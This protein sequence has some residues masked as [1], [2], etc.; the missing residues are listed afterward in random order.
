MGAVEIFF[1][2]QAL[3]SSGQEPRR[4]KTNL[5][6]DILAGDKAGTEG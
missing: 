3:Q 1:R 5:A 2:E 4:Y 6:A